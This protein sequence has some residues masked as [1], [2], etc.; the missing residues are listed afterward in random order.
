MSLQRKKGETEKKERQQSSQ[1]LSDVP[2]SQC[3]YLCA[4]VC[5]AH[6]PSRSRRELCASIPLRVHLAR[7]VTP[8]PDASGDV[9]PRKLW[10]VPLADD[11][12]RCGG[13]RKPPHYPTK[14]RRKSLWKCRRD[15]LRVNSFCL[16]F[17]FRLNK[18]LSLLIFYSYRQFNV[19]ASSGPCTA[20]YFYT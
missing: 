7:D 4:E 14:Q 12:Q 5:G 20:P 3:M 1:V 13:E 11:V 18:T 8:Q 17:W 6:C 16:K 9:T 19:L 10:G 15:P 2:L